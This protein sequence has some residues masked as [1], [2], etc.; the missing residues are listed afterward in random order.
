MN[1][2]QIFSSN[3]TYCKANHVCNFRQCFFFFLLD[4]VQDGK[5]WNLPW[6]F[7]PLDFSCQL[8]ADVILERSPYKCI[9]PAGADADGGKGLARENLAEIAR[10]GSSLL[11]SRL[12]PRRCSPL[13]SL[14]LFNVPSRSFS[15]SLFLSF[16]FF[17]APFNLLAVRHGPLRASDM[18]IPRLLIKRRHRRTT[19]N[20]YG[21]RWCN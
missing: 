12:L 4:K 15:L 19:W 9:N 21:V 18:N 8:W 5:N 13:F 16:F 10:L 17:V 14:F 20:A 6:F 3:F 2:F 11:S 7:R 1:F